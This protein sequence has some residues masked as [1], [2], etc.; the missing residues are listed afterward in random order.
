MPLGQ[1]YQVGKPFGAENTL[2]AP[3]HFLEASG[4]NTGAGM[5]GKPQSAM[6]LTGQPAPM[7]DPMALV[8][9]SAKT[10]IAKKRKSNTG[11]A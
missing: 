1:G 3:A 10:T 2:Q 4:Y 9:G 7:P 11:R 8:P 5:A 6:G